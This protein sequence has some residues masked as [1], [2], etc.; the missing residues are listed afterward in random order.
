[1][2]FIKNSV[3]EQID[4][5]WKEQV[6]LPQDNK[7]IKMSSNIFTFYYSLP[8]ILQAAI[9]FYVN[10]MISCLFYLFLKILSHSHWAFVYPRK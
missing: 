1:M 2:N 7:E 6:N 10:L 3:F 8:S 5:Q 9:L 4:N